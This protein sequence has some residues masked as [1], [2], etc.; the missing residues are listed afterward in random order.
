MYSRL[1]V[2][3]ILA[4]FPIKSGSEN[5]VGWTTHTSLPAELARP[6]T[7]VGHDGNVYMFGGTNGLKDYKT[8]YVYHPHINTWSDGTTM[9][10]ATEGAAAVTLP[11]GRII[12]LGE[13]TGCH[14]TLS[15]TI[16]NIV[17][18][19]N[20]KSHAWRL[21]APMHTPRYSFARY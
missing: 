20:R 7:A 16:Y 8:T 18:V 12:V 14:N 2:I 6:A 1:M 11:Y 13:G 17:Q 21:A 3:L 10:I 4:L 9:P 5:R 15:C 19:Y